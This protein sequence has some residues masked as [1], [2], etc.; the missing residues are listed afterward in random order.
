MAKVL[1]KSAIIVD[2]NSLFHHQKKDILVENDRIV[3][4]ADAIEM[5]QKMQVIDHSGLHV[6]PGWMDFRC[7]FAEPGHEYKEG[8]DNGLDAAAHAGF[9]AVC[10]SPS[11]QP[12]V[13]T[14]SGVEFLI[15]RAQGHAVTLIPF[16][17][18]SK[19]MSGIELAEFYDMQ[20]GGALAFS[21][22]KHPIQSNGLLFKGLTYAQAL[23]ALILD[24]P[25]DLEWMA[26]GQMHEGEMSTRLGM[27][28]IPEEAEAILVARDI[29]MLK[30]T[31]GKLHIGPVST[32]KSLD[33]I[34]K[35]KREGL[36]I[37]AEVAHHHLYLTDQELVDFDSRFKVMPPLRDEKNRKALIKGLEKGTIDVISSD[38]WPHDYDEK[39]L[40]FGHS[41]FGVSGLETS[42]SIGLMATSNL[43]LTLE[44]LISGPR[45][46]L[47]F[48][49]P[50]IAEGEIAELTL[51]DPELEW[52]VEESNLVS[53]S[54]ITP[55]LGKTLKGKALGIINN[56]QVFITH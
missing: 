7:N 56:N 3:S 41:A 38:H 54:K 12:V 29:A 42:F 15:K 36:N 37:T 5:D 24:F 39:V 47:G 45:R 52:V 9:T 50:V 40:E 18:F 4:I 19:N 51:F 32:K 10:V 2:P 44:K 11:T 13:D 21:D 22:D 34:A 53:K 6:S 20:Q 26:S 25:M 14:R 8:I 27:K 48:D 1:I 30:Y 55:Y 43:D 17:A 31:G 33:L 49:S 28:G 35:A 23:N 16:G 46:V